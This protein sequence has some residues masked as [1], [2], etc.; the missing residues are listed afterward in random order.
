MER[1][2]MQVYV[3]GA[4]EAIEMYKEAFDAEVLWV[5]PAPNGGIYHSEISVY[6]QVVSIADAADKRITGNTMQFCLDFG[7]GH[8]DEV[9]KA[10]AVLS[11]NAEILCPLDKCD[12]SPLMADLID[13][14]GVR[15][16]LFV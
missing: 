16:C 8:E 6:G 1:S 15:W 12:Y 10:Y 5:V 13:R 4:A 2:M 11:Q 7:E 3:N 9:K 14:F